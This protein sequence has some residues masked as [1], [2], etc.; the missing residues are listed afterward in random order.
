MKFKYLIVDDEPLARKLIASHAS[1][2]ENMELAGECA[3]ALGAI[4]LLRTK[5]I[6]LIFLDI[7]MPE[8]SGLDFIRA[9]KD[10]PAIILT[11]AHRDFAIEAFDLNVV[12]Y[13]LKPISFERF[14]KSV[15][16]FFD[17]EMGH[18]TK[19]QTTDGAEAFIY[20]KA[21]RKSHKV[22]LDEILYIESLDDYVKVFLKSK[23]LVTHENIS[24]LEQKLPGNRF[25]RIH[26][27]FIVSLR[28][29]TTVSSDTVQVGAKELPFG[30]A[31]KKSALASISFMPMK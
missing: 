2:M 1:K 4:N 17:R 18:N 24:T 8:L 22:T 5:S 20:L 12:D 7:Q 16:K 3:N 14:F 28:E 25:V 9:L 10:P 13:L 19:P 6:N 29:I 26:R 11:T 23:I 31:F 27:S 21:D 30:R 15:N